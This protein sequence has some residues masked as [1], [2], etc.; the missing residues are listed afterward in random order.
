MKK[1]WLSHTIIGM[2][3]FDIEPSDSEDYRGEPFIAYVPESE[4]SESLETIAKLKTELEQ[5]GKDKISNDN[6]YLKLSV[7]SQ[8]EIK[9]L[10]E[11]LDRAMKSHDSRFDGKLQSDYDA[12]L[13]G[14]KGEK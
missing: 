4:L 7:S 3:E 14:D 9:N 13:S 11:L 5:L 8:A 12:L 10:R 2:E 6:D 1:V